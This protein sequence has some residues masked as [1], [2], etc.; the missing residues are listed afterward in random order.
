MLSGAA[1]LRRAAKGPLDSRDCAAG[2][3]PPR[4]ER[5][6]RRM[7]DAAARSARALDR[8]GPVLG[9]PHAC[10]R[11][12]DVDRLEPWPG[13]AVAARSPAIGAIGRELRQLRLE[14]G[15]ALCLQRARV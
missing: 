13:A 4:L 11:S 1:R 9:L 8:A 6:T 5:R 3:G 10:H 2:L 14:S 12:R 15:H 7:V